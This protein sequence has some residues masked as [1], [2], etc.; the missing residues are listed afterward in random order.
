M[1][2]ATRPND[3]TL[4]GNRTAASVYA[5]LSRGREQVIEQARRIA[6]ISLPHYFPPEGYKVGDNL[7]P[8]NQSILARCIVN[9]ASRIMLTAL[10]AGGLPCCKFNIIEHKMQKEV[11]AD[12]E[13]YAETKLAL[14]R[15]AIAHTERIEDT[16]T[17]TALTEGAIQ[18]LLAGNVCWNGLDLDFPTTHKMTEYVTRRNATGQ[19]LLTILQRTINLLDQSPQI[20]AFIRNVREQSASPTSDT[21]SANDPAYG[22]EVMVHCVCKLVVLGK[23]KEDRVWLYWEEFKGEIIPGTESRAPFDQPHLYPAWMVPVYGSNWGLSYC[24]LYEGDMWKVENQEAN[25][26]D[27]ADMAALTWLF[28]DPAGLTSKKIVEKARNLKVMSGR[29][30]DISVFRLEKF[31]DFAFVQNNTDGAAKR[32]MQAFLMV[33]SVQR[34]GDRVTAEEWRSMTRELNEAMGGLYAS[35]AQGFIKAIILR[36]IGLHQFEDKELRDLP[37]GIIRVGVITGIDSLG[38]DTDEMNLENA[39]AVLT[40]LVP[41]QALAQEISI[42]NLTTRVFTGYNVKP[43]GLVPTKEERAQAMA[44]AK[45][46]AM[47]QT[48]LD[49]AAGPVAGEMAK[50]AAAVGVPQAQAMIEAQQQG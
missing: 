29:A 11:D 50:G 10:P 27:G 5:D 45:Q 6:R 1:A 47:Q 9:L 14:G 39:M 38:T 12:P 2:R 25:L 22:D 31:N 18:L 28:V 41:P 37:K 34:P 48:I 36:A 44:Q 7:P 33:S 30:V 17:R 4:D 23:A 35:L 13:L 20:A 49:K 19:P 16:Q 8:P 32:L 24:S 3:Y 21:A 43:D 40:K 15:R 46:D 26:S 42:P